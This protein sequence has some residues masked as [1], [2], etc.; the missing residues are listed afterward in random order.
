MEDILKIVVELSKTPLPNVLVIGGLFFIFLSIVGKFG[1]N[2]VVNPKKQTFAAVLGV[3]LLVIGITITSIKQPIESPDSLTRE[4]LTS[5]SWQFLHSEGDIISPQV[6]LDPSGTILGV[7]HPN[8]SRWELKDGM[9]TFY[10]L[11][12]QPTTNFTEKRHEA[13]KVV[14]SGQLLLSSQQDVVIHV[15]KEL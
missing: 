13:G 2:V 5:R 12:G 9:L 1:A 7:N 6:N 14:L 8:E 11:D 4:F 10:H 3:V 15:L